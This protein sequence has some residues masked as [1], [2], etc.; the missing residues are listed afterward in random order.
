MAI[1][2]HLLKSVRVKDADAIR[3]TYY[4]DSEERRQGLY[5]ISLINLISWLAAF[6]HYGQLIKNQLTPYEAGKF[7]KEALSLHTQMREDVW[8]EKVV[9]L[10]PGFL[11]TPLTTKC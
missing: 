11:S 7:V 4:N 3:P 5:K 8:N 2:A 1:F 6:L 9:E 10:F